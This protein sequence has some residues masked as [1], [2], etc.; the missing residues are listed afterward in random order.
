[1][2]F[3]FW[4]LFSNAFESIKDKATRENKLKEFQ[5][6]FLNLVDVVK[7]LDYFIIIF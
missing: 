5:P 2:T 3:R 6:L 7:G 4:Y 1:M